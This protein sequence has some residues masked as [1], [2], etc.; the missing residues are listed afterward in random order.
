M[1]IH[2]VF[3]SD[4]LGSIGMEECLVLNVSYSSNKGLGRTIVSLNPSPYRGLCY[5]TVFAPPLG[6][7]V[8]SKGWLDHRCYGKC[9]LHL[10]FLS[11][12]IITLTLP[13]LLT[14]YTPYFLL[15]ILLTSCFP[16]SLLLA[17]HTP[18]FLLLIL[19]TSCFSYSLLLASQSW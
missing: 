11:A 13:L 9:I 5:P 15:L 12:V 2:D 8:L 6:M 7:H 3:T 19:L 10:S 18:Y 14:S 17:S 4:D 16:Y 1:D